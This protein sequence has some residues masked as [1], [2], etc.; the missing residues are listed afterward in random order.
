M[1]SLTYRSLCPILMTPEAP[2]E[3]LHLL[4]C[5]LVVDV[6]KGK[7]S[8]HRGRRGRRGFGWW[9]GGEYPEKGV[10][11]YRHPRKGGTRKLEPRIS[12]PLLVTF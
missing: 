11:R 4:K 10:W 1:L 5:C 9:R 8:D 2:R 6:P 12:S 7:R 3:L